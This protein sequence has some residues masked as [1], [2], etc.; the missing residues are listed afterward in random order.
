MK[1]MYL[2][3]KA[4]ELMAFQFTQ[5]QEQHSLQDSQPKLKKCDRAMPFHDRDRLYQAKEILIN[6]LK[7][8]V[9]Y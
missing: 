7:S 2:E 1:R 6:N 8:S 9:I 4:L 3:A 5:F